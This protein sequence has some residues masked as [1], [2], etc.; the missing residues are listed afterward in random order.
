M[1]NIAELVVCLAEGS[2][3]LHEGT[4]MPRPEGAEQ[5]CSLLVFVLFK[6]FEMFTMSY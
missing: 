5:L 2:H 6:V 4:K 1:Q 3:R